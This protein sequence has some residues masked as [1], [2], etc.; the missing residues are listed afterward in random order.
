MGP[1]P[2]CYKEVPEPGKTLRVVGALKTKRSW[3]LLLLEGPHPT[4]CSP[5]QSREQ[6]AVS[7]TGIITLSCLMPA[8]QAEDLSPVEPGTPC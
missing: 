4:S 3:I 1:A 5:T 2:H 7:N 8:Y 6:R